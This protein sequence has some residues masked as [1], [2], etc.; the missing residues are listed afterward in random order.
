MT[1]FARSE[2]R[3][4]CD[5][6]LEIG[7][8]APTL[9]EG[10]TARDLAAHLV[11]RDSSPAAVGIVVRRLAPVTQWAQDR[12]ARREWPHLV[13]S[14][15]KPAFYAP[16]SWEQ[17]EARV[18]L[19]EFFVHHEDLRRA[20]P[21]WSP[22]P[23][24]TG[25]ERA[26]WRLLTSQAKALYRKSPTGVQLQRT[27]GAR[28]VAKAGA[29][30]VVTGPVAELLLHAYGRTEHARVTIEGSTQARRALDDTELGF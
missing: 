12:Q 27:D 20:Q 7:P 9:C 26:L 10:W 16:M 23:L 14:V 8:D 24:S 6:L 5:L 22:R 19:G 2:R 30:V 29:G 18:N 1:S 15:R 3:A 4:L 21:D 25:Q 13:E 11:V 17:V 28:I